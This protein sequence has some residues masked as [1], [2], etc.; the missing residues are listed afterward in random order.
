MVGGQ[1]DAHGLRADALPDRIATIASRWPASISL[2]RT[3]ASSP[4]ADDAWEDMTN[5]ARPVSFR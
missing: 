1:Y 3:F 5:P 4:P 2:R